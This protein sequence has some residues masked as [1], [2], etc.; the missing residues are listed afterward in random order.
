MPHTIGGASV[1]L[2]CA[3][4]AGE[5]IDQLCVRLLA[6][7]QMARQPASVPTDHDVLAVPRRVQARKSELLRATPPR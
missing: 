2:C 3:P 5:G 4:D 7:A 6:R 1:S